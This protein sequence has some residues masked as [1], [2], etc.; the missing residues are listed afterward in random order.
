MLHLI[1]IESIFYFINLI[2]VDGVIKNLDNNNFKVFN[3][4]DTKFIFF[5][6]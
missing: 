3:F 5:F 4:V 6:F 2:Y 1:R